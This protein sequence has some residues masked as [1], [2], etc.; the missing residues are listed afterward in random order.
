MHGKKKIT[1]LQLKKFTKLVQ[2]RLKRIPVAYLVG[3]KYF[4]G[5][6]FAVTEDTLIP[7]PESE[8]LV[9]RAIQNGARTILDVGTGSGCIAISIAKHMRG[10][11]YATDI[12]EKA[13]AVARGNALTHK[14]K[15][16]FNKRNLLDGLNK[17][18]DL[19]IA[20]LPYVPIS[21]YKKLHKNLRYEPK[22]ALT[23]G[24]NSF[25]LYKT[26]LQQLPSHLTAQGSCLLEIDPL[27]K[28]YL[29]MWVKQYLPDYIIIF[30]KDLNKLIRYA[31]IKKV[32]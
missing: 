31:E 21:D 19:I 8:W 9:E 29:Q 15:I 2:Q 5:L 27:T 3:H 24:T 17:K 10:L 28:P 26:L 30:F 1:A 16:D 7:R 32:P 14:V 11:V 20:N 18:F 22:S 6:K 4:F 12:S 23:D 13:L 25:V